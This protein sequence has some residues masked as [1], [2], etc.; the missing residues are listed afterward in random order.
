MSIA[1]QMGRYVIALIRALVTEYIRFRV[2]RRT[3]ISTNIKASK[4][5]TNFSGIE[6]LRYVGTIGFFLRSFRCRWRPRCQCTAHSRS[7]GC[8]A[9]SGSVAGDPHLLYVTEMTKIV[10]FI[11]AKLRRRNSR[12]RRHSDES[13]R[14]RWKSFAGPDRH[15]SS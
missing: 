14:C 7:L 10:I 9:G 1:E 11:V 4:R 12:R 3:S 15:H 8:H 2:L 6:D 13:S 5:R